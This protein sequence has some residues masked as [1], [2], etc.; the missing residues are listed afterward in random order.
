MVEPC[1]H[2]YRA[3]WPDGEIYVDQIPQGYL[4]LIP[5][6]IARRLFFDHG[7]DPDR[8][9]IVRLYGADYEMLRAPLGAAAATPIVNRLAPVNNLPRYVFRNAAP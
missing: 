8:M 7:Y 5:F 9:L 3:I 1:G 4:D 6:M 2:R